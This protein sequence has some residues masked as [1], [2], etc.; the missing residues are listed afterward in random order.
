MS[1]KAF[2]IISLMTFAFF[3]GAGNLIF[4]PFAGIQ[5]GALFGWA[6]L[7]YILV[8][9][10]LSLLA[11]IAVAAVGRA[12][13]LTMDLPK[14]MGVVFWLVIYMII[15]PVFGAPRTAVVAYDI[16]ISPFVSGSAS[17]LSLFVFTLC[18]FCIALFLL[19]SPGRLVNIVGGIL[20]PLLLLFLLVVY[21]VM[22]F[23]PHPNALE[24]I[25]IH[26]GS[27]FGYG[28][29]QG[30]LTMDTLAA[31]AFGSVIIKAV[32]E[33][34]VADDRQVVRMTIYTSVVAG[35][36]LAVVYLG[37][38]YMGATNPQMADVVTN[39]GQVLALFVGKHLGV[40]GQFILA[41]IIL[42]ACMTTAVGLITSCAEYFNFLCKSISYRAW[43]IA[44]CLVS[45]CIANL[46]LD[47]II[48]LSIPVVVALYP[49]TIVVI[50]TSLMRK[51]LVMDYRFV[52]LTC[53]VTFAFS[54]MGAVHHVDHNLFNHSWVTKIPLFA[55]GL[56]W[57]VPSVIMFVV[58]LVVSNIWLKPCAESSKS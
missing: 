41:L 12:S 45:F 10:G 16:G 49:L 39:G 13:F 29:L 7:G 32:R 33:R 25:P 30:Y 27:A 37:L 21:C 34:G 20:T 3:F 58:G 4:P 18:F 48:N 56:S 47:R 40:T 43:V 9:V 35:L 42:L 44:L 36:L 14:W 54:V 1:R 28:M 55:Q 52:I 24:S 6:Y 26:K 2:L 19:F 46:G 51:R 11:I 57:L 50:F 22:F 15:G 23:S 38:F 17:E 31:L 8:D 53:L 5:T